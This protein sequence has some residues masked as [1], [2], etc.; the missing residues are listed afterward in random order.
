MKTIYFMFRLALFRYVLSFS[1]STGDGIVELAEEEEGR[2]ME[3][4]IG[5]VKR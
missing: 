4:G 3:R 5:L 2:K 1:F